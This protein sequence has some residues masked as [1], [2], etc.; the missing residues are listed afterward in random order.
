MVLI[1]TW[2]CHLPL[3]SLG[4]G[5]SVEESVVWT[6]ARTRCS[7]VTWSLLSSSS[8]DILCTSAYIMPPTMRLSSKVIK[9]FFMLNSGAWILN[10][11]V[12]NHHILSIILLINVKMPTIVPIVGIL[13]FMSSINLMFS[14]LLM[15]MQKTFYD[16]K[17]RCYLQR[18]F[19]AHQLTSCRLEWD[20]EIKQ[21]TSWENLSSGFLTRS[22]ANRAKQP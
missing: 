14:W 13:T 8:E 2:L 3:R 19:S 21:A 10:C 1:I 5:V 7:V 15:S 16:L 17:A 9:T 22:D 11:S 12:L 4:P 18:T 20:H 6:S